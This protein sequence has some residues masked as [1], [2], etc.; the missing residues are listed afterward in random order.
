MVRVFAIAVVLLCAQPV[1][2][3]V[4]QA[5]V[6]SVATFETLDTV[7]DRLEKCNTAGMMES[8]DPA[9]V[10]KALQKDIVCL[11]GLANDI[12][13]VFYPP[14]AFG[15]GRPA[16]MKAALDQV[17]TDLLPLFVALQTRPLA[18][19]PSCD[20]FYTRQAYEMNARFLSALI[21]EMTERLKDDSPI[22]TE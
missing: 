6:P 4:C 21:L 19:D 1:L 2:V 16:S 7:P 9:P 14:D 10:I 20:S 11:T 15:Q 13:L 8:D 22:H 17:N 12:A 5:A 3:V 18:C